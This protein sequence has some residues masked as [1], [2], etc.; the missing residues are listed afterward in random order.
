[1]YFKRY[2]K[3]LDGPSMR[4]LV[5]SLTGSD[6]V[7]VEKIDIAYYKPDNVFCIWPISHTCGLWLELPN[8]YNNFCELREEFN[9]FLQ[10]NS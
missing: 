3:G 9:Q 8:T 1:M 4:K 2:I 5:Q 10:R 7:G 6:V